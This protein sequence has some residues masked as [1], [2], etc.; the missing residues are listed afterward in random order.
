MQSYIF[1][2][3]TT[4]D[5]ARESISES[6][7][8]FFASLFVWV[9]IIISL[10]S[11]SLLYFIAFFIALYIHYTLDICYILCCWVGMML[12]KRKAIHPS[13]SIYT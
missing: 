8:V 6:S 13:L 3:V 9:F 10:L 2:G 7:L 5:S 1:L 11:L 4:G 12:H